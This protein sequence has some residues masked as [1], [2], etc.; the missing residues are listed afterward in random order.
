MS[1]KRKTPTRQYHYSLEELKFWTLRVD[2]DER[3]VLCDQ[4]FQCQAVN[5]NHGPEVIRVCPSR[6]ANFELWP[7]K[8]RVVDVIFD[9]SLENHGNTSSLVELSFAPYPR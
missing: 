9:L 1:K 5:K 7:G 6:G 3:A 8:L 2:P 4:V